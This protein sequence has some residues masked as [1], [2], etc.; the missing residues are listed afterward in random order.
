M[1]WP[2][3]RTS[4]QSRRSPGR[5]F[6]AGSRTGGH[7]SALTPRMRYTCRAR[8]A[9]QAEGA[10]SFFFSREDSHQLFEASVGIPRGNRPDGRDA[11]DVA[12]SGRGRSAAHGAGL[13]AASELLLFHQ[14]VDEKRNIDHH[15]LA[16]LV[17]GEI[18]LTNPS[19]DGFSWSSPCQSSSRSPA[20]ATPGRRAEV[21]SLDFFHFHGLCC[22]MLVYK[23]LWSWTMS[24]D[25]VQTIALGLCHVHSQIMIN[26]Y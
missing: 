23:G 21:L 22:T 8:S 3:L 12:G 14:L 25:Y 11:S 10:A 17:R 1:G 18:A 5:G 24:I 15:V 2:A 4:T 26:T 16:D 20:T 19:T 6:G 13:P 7:G 9:G